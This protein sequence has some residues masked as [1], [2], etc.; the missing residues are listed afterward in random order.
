[1]GINETKQMMPDGAVMLKSADGAL[2]VARQFVIDGPDMFEIAAGELR[3][4]KGKYKAL[5]EQRLG[6]TRDMDTAKKK[7]MDLFR[8][9]LERLTQVE[10]AYKGAMLE[11]QKVEQTKARAEQAKADALAR[12]ERQRFEAIAREQ[13]AEATKLQDQADALVKAGNVAAAA[14]VAAQAEMAQINAAM[15]ETTALVIAAPVSVSAAPKVSGVT[16]NSIWKGLVTDKAVL[17]AHIATHPELLDWVD[18]KPTPINQ[19]AKALK[20]AMRI[21]GVEAYEEAGISSR[22]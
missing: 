17:L 3:E 20:T 7:V 19:M 4:V 2:L 8:P 10:G 14:E 21:P 1:M 16:F 6:I 5:E 11:Y 22:S 15:M 13:A 12:A 9:A 18:I